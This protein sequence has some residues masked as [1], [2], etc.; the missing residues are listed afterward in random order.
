MHCSIN[1]IK[2]R[3]FSTYLEKLTYLKRMVKKSISAKINVNINMVNFA[4]K[5]YI[6]SNKVYEIIV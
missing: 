1:L 6:E 5:L 4:I 2:T 3:T